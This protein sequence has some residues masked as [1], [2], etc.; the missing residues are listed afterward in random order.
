MEE[1]DKLKIYENILKKSYPFISRLEIEDDNYNA[2]LFIAARIDIGKFSEIYDIKKVSSAASDFGVTN[3]SSFAF[4][5]NEDKKE[6]LRKLKVEM[7]SLIEE[8]R[9]ILPEK[10]RLKKMPAL[11]TFIGD[12]STFR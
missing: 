12:K 7:N 2:T 6:K 10:Y 3:L 1:K 9:N 11:F 8:L 5:E 4:Y